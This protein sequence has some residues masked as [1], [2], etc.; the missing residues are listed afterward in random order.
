MYT[1]IITD[2]CMYIPIILLMLEIRVG[3]RLDF[4]IVNLTRNVK[5]IVYHRDDIGIYRHAI[6]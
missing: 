4:Y 3:K 2:L 1:K 6:A 5:R